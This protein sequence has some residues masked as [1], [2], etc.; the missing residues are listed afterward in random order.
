MQPQFFNVRAYG[1]MDFKVMA[2]TKFQAIAKVNQMFH[3]D[4][5]HDPLTGKVI[6]DKVLALGFM[7]LVP[8]QTQEFQHEFHFS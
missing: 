7:V 1:A 8:D 6:T 5:E 2:E 4:H 3:Q